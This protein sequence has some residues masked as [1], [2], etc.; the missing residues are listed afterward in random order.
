MIGLGTIDCIDSYITF[1]WFACPKKK[2]YEGGGYKKPDF[3]EE[4][5]EFKSSTEV[6]DFTLPSIELTEDS[7][8]YSREIERF[9]KAIT[10]I[11]ETLDV[12]VEGEAGL[13]EI[14]LVDRK[15]AVDFL[16]LLVE[17]MYKLTG[18]KKKREDEE[19]IIAILIAES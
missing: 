15:R 8:D 2:E 10:F 17:Q 13:M 16:L 9:E 18:I 5:I 7:K 1:G 3:Y 19:I 11:E 14:Y 4:K 12:E 6:F